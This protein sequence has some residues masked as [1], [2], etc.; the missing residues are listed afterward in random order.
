M[1][2][3]S[4]YV[5]AFALCCGVSQTLTSCI[6]ET[7]EPDDVK[8][9]R[10]AEIA[11]VNAD[12]QKTLAEAKESEA[13]AAKTNADAAYR[14]AE[15]AIKEVDKAVKE[16]ASAE[17]IQEAIAKYKSS[18]KT[19]TNND[20]S[21]AK[22]AAKAFLPDQLNTDAAAAYT[23]YVAAKNAYLG[24]IDEFGNW[25]KGTVEELADA[26]Q[27][28]I[29]NVDAIAD[30]KQ[31]ILD[32]E[33]SI[34]AS[35]KAVEDLNKGLNKWKEDYTKGSSVSAPDESTMKGWNGTFDKT[36]DN[37]TTLYDKGLKVW[38]Y[39]INTENVTVEKSTNK[40]ALIKANKAQTDN[41]L[42]YYD[43]S[44]APGVYNEFLAA[45]QANDQ[46][47]ANYDEAKAKYDATIAA[48]QAINQ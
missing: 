26:I 45:Q 33:A 36:A 41:K 17:E 27:D 40:L 38:N 19:Y 6:E 35:N 42:W 10:Q 39:L 43:N 25:V 24:Y 2:K 28:T 16:G 5:A 15:T 1:K 47:K 21:A 3:I 34:A 4:Y 20:V 22:T 37:A 9:L 48:F 44:Y 13:T 12:A 32:L 29:N 14:N 18:I 31:T 7:E 46:A 11:K 23:N 8:A 30:K